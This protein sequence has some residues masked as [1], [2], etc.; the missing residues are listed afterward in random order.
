VPGTERDP[1]RS[2]VWMSR[3]G[4]EE[5]IDLPLHRYT[6]PRLS[7]DEKR[8][9]V[10]IPEQENDIWIWDLLRKTL[11]RFTFD[12][13]PDQFPVWMQPDGSRIIFASSRSGISNLY[14]QAADN[15]G[16]VERLTTSTNAQYPTSISRDGKYLVFTET[17]QETGND[18]GLLT[19]DGKQSPDLIIHSKFSESNGE[20]S[21]DKRWIAYQSNE[22]GAYQIYVRPFPKVDTGRWQVST[23]GGTRPL[24]AQ[25]GAELFYEHG[26]AL[27]AAPILISEQTLS[28]GNPTK[29]CTIPPSYN[30][31]IT[32]WGRNYDASPDGKRFLFVKGIV[33]DPT[34]PTTS[35]SMVVVLNWQEDLKARAG[36]K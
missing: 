3:Q 11:T 29:I 6:Y 24:W 1:H 2:L 32:F 15:A 26:N 28:A 21:P 7:P 9:A 20:I 36:A 8:V 12:P 4:Q 35:A 34:S 27:M 5:P 16:S 23:V 30:V 33:N 31:S 17:S 18:I 13:G 19:M 25:N 14:S 10:A 22:S